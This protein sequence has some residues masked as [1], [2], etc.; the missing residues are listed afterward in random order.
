M[1][2]SI[3]DSFIQE[4]IV[5]WI[6][7]GDP[8]SQ[9]F[10]NMDLG[11]I[12]QL[13]F[14]EDKIEGC[15][16]LTRVNYATL[17]PSKF[18]VSY[19]VGKNEQLL[20]VK[21][22]NDLRGFIDDENKRYFHIIR[23]N[24][25][26][27]GLLKFNIDSYKLRTNP[28]EVINDFEFASL[29]KFD[30]KK[31]ALEIS[32]LMSDRFIGKLAKHKAVAILSQFLNKKNISTSYFFLEGLEPASRIKQ[33]MESR[34]FEEHI[35]EISPSTGNTSAFYPSKK[36]WI[37]PSHNLKRGS[38]ITFGVEQRIAIISSYDATDI[39]QNPCEEGLSLVGLGA[40]A[41]RIARFDS[42]LK[43]EGFVDS[44]MDYGAAVS[45][46]SEGNLCIENFKVAKNKGN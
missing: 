13:K 31:Q 33:F 23:D 3:L 12:V 20:L 7:D 1:E 9:E 36:N 25:Y 45:H 40:E 28:K 24:N 22:P 34:D 46:I 15:W 11:D 27:I 14:K 29:V 5:E 26:S 43:L 32:K 10:S 37:K 18:S 2:F 4:P 19:Q 17:L 6:P 44:C 16:K 21:I 41:G 8:M 38:L 30:S 39:D 35:L 42:Y